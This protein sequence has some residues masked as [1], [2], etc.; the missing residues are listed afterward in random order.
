MMKDDVDVESKYDD[1][2]D[3]IGIPMLSSLSKQTSDL[4]HCKEGIS[5]TI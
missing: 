3:V 4:T 2:I 5:L 1:S